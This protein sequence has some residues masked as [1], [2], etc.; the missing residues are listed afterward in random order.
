MTASASTVE[1]VIRIHSGEVH[2][3]YC[4]WAALMT[5]DTED[6]VAHFLSALWLDHVARVHGQP[7]RVQ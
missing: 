7:S 5:G 4:A 6:D 3:P 2:C 1:R